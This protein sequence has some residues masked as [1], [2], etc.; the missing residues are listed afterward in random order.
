[1][2]NIILYHYQHAAKHSITEWFTKAAGTVNSKTQPRFWFYKHYCLHFHLK[3]QFSRAVEWAPHSLPLRY[4]N[5]D[6]GN[7][8]IVAEQ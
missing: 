4:L 8:I 2:Q 6:Y 1:M 3:C 7:K 5:N